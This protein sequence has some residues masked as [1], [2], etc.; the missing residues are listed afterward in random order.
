MTK[1][2][3]NRRFSHE[4]VLLTIGGFLLAIFLAAVVYSF[5]FLINN[6]LPAITAGDDNTGGNETRFNLEGFEE[7]KL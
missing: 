3:K 2:K 4:A 5:T 7:L 6:V 1:D